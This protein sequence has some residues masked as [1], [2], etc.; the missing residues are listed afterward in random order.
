[1]YTGGHG[2]DKNYVTAVK[3]Y[4]K[5]ADQGEAAGQNSLGTM[6]AGGFGVVKDY[7]AAVKWYKRLSGKP[8]SP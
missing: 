7:G 6:Y 3:W 4:K 1:M 2:V 5:A 8:C